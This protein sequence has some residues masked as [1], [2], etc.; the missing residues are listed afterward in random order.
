MDFPLPEQLT[1]D[2]D[3]EPFDCENA[4]LNIWLKNTA[5]TSASA[6][7]ARS[8]VVV[9]AGTPRVIAYTCLAAGS[10]ARERAPGKLSRN[11]PDPIPA[12]VI[13][14]LAVDRGYQEEGL[15]GLLLIDALTRA[16]HAADLVRARAVTVNPIDESA[17]RFYEHHGF[18]ELSGAT[19]TLFL[20]MHEF[21]LSLGIEASK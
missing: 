14:R 12:I 6:G 10:V 15:G 13:G 8:Y 7:N 21:R 3:V 18:K 9:D 1:G 16:A 19:D 17:H 11:S 20:M 4:S 2:H 5:L